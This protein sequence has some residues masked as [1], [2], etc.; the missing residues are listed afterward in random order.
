VALLGADR[1]S[2]SK[3][4]LKQ[5]SGPLAERRVAFDRGCGRMSQPM[6]GIA[7][8]GDDR[9]EALAAQRRYDGT[10]LAILPVSGPAENSIDLLGA[11]VRS[12]AAHC[13]QLPTS[14]SATNAGRTPQSVHPARR[15]EPGLS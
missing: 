10:A 15:S 13:R 8:S 4:K 7:R 5:P 11:F 3:A 6:H 14:P 12:H 1:Q 2:L 9:H